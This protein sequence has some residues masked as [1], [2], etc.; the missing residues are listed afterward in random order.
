MNG[1]HADLDS[2]SRAPPPSSSFT[3]PLSRSLISPSSRAVDPFS[4]AFDIKDVTEEDK[5]RILSKHLVS[6]QERRAS[7]V[8]TPE[9]GFA[10]SSSHVHLPPTTQAANESGFSFSSQ[11]GMSRVTRE[12]GPGED[13]TEEFTLPLDVEGGDVT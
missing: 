8:A 2:T 4:E 6:A 13:G 3:R 9:P 12:L 1:P 5:L 11:D 10:S 7:N